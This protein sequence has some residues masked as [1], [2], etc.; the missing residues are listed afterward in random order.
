MTLKD[1]GIYP[2]NFISSSGYTAV[3]AIVSDLQRDL[4]L[5][6]DLFNALDKAHLTLS[7]QFRDLRKE[8]D[9]NVSRSKLQQTI[10][11]SD[12]SVTERARLEQLEKY[13]K[14]IQEIPLLP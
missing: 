10:T 3:E 1:Y 11:P 9:F 4:Q 13:I 8:R 7:N 12:L 5:Q 14:F 2:E 6:K